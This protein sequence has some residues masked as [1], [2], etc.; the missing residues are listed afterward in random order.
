MRASARE[1]FF[2]QYRESMTIAPPDPD[3]DTTGPRSAGAQVTEPRVVVPPEAVSPAPEGRLDRIERLAS[4]LWRRPPWLA[5]TVI[6]A[7]VATIAAYIL[8]HNPTDD[9]QDWTGPC[10]FKTLTGKDCPGCGGTRMVWYLLHGDITQAGAHHIVALLA[11]PFLLYAYVA[12]VIGR[13]SAR[14]KPPSLRIPRWAYI[15]YFGLWAL[16]AVLRNLP[17]EPFNN[18]YV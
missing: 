3:G 5:P 9:T 14:L 4:R 6:A 7:G 8:T 16:F 2:V 12:M 18:F 15:T 11:V 13:I 10:A 1:V 17:W